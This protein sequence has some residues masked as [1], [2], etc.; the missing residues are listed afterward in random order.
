M[1]SEETH[2]YMTLD[3]NLSDFLRLIRFMCV[4]LWRK[5]AKL[6]KYYLMTKT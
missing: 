4:S 5:N 2:H 6:Q 1:M 3:G